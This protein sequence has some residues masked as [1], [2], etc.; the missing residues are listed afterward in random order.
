MPPRAIF[1]DRDGV[2]NRERGTHTWQLAHFEMLPDVPRA[3]FNL[4]QTGWKLVVITNQSGIALGRYG[5]ADV[6]R[7]HDYLHSMLARHGVALTDI[8]YCPHHPD[9]GRC[10][11][12]KPGTLLLEK[13]CARH[14]IDPSASVMIGDRD[15]DVEAGSLLGMRGI[16]VAANNSL[17]QVLQEHGLN[18]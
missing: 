15:R 14:G 13:A 9:K 7:V 11:C 6:A 17:W 3:L 16:K 18:S 2:I 12:R 10:L 4:Q 5:H 8:L 1:L